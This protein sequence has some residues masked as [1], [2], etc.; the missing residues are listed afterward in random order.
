VS[1]PAAVVSCGAI[2]SNMAGEYRNWELEARRFRLAKVG[3]KR[4]FLSMKVQEIQK[5]V[6]RHPFRPFAIRLNNGEEYTFKDRRDVGAPKDYHILIYFGESE[7]VRIDAD[8]ITEI[9]EN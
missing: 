2:N 3:M 7:S 1:F 8:S 9:I 4:I 5:F 6:E